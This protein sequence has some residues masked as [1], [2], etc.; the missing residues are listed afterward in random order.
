VRG[1][2][3]AVEKDR[4]PAGRRRREPRDDEGRAAT[5]LRERP[6]VPDESDGP[7]I[8]KLDHTAER[9][10]ARAD[11]RLGSSALRPSPSALSHCSTTKAGTR[12]II[13]S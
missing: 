2:E 7:G 13:S 5:I 4:R 3:G 8:L 10:A 12:P 6:A 9:I 1:E 11:L